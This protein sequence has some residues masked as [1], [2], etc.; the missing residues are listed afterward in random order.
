MGER[1]HGKGMK[2]GH[3]VAAHPL[4]YG[5]KAFHWE[6]RHLATIALFK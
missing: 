3:P 6:R 5:K 4:I 2:I 1:V